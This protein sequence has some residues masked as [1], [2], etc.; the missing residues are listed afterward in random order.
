[1]ITI[2]QRHR[3]TDRRTDGQSCLGNTAL[4]VASRGINAKDYFKTAFNHYVNKFGAHLLLDAN[5]QLG[6]AVRGRDGSR[7]KIFK[8][9]FGSV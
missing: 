5:S 3:Q 4:R 6:A 2:P 8:F 1:M 9:G 7:T